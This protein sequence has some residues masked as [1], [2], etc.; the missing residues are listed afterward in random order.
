[1][2]RISVV[3]LTPKWTEGI[4]GATGGVAAKVVTDPAGL[5]LMLSFP[6]KG[7]QRALFSVP[8]RVGPPDPETWEQQ[9]DP[10][11]RWGL[12]RLGPGVWNLSP[13]VVVGEV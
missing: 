4:M 13:S 7:G 5:T 9:G 8:C 6:T 3:H 10:I 2:N 12:V 11:D 1:M